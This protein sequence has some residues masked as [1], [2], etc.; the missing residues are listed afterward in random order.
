MKKAI[1]KGF[2]DPLFEKVKKT[3]TNSFIK[4]KETGA[5]VCVVIEGKP[6]VDLW[7]GYS[8]AKRKKEWQ[9]D[10]L[11]NIFSS[12]KGITSIC[13]LRLIDQGKLDLDEKVSTY[14]PKF[15]GS[16]KDL[17]TVRMLLNHQSGM[18]GL[19]DKVPFMS[20]Y[21]W[22]YMASLFEGH[23]PWWTPGTQHG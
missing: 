15:Q 14:W 17:I 23:D 5:S 13:A 19:K 7:A 9:K 11:V 20:L 8:D 2:C 3:F 4:R 16:E 1:I 22:E 12:S 6:V 21:D 10:T 18:I